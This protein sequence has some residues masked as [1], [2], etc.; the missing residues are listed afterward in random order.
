MERICCRA[1]LLAKVVPTRK[2]FNLALPHAATGLLTI[3]VSAPHAQQHVQ[4]CNCML[5][6][7]RRSAV[8][9]LYNGLHTT[10]VLYVHASSLS[11]ALSQPQASFAVAKL[12]PCNCLLQ[13]HAVTL[14]RLG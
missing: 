14:T 6:L 2:A 3:L 11:A 7:I 4:P 12:L 1:L 9:L 8:Y 13:F 10:S 5:L